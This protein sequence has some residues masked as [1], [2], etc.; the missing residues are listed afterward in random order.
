[1]CCSRS[2][3]KSPPPERQEK[4][5][6]ATETGLEGPG[7]ERATGRESATAPRPAP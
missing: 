1:M 4:I 5:P 6:V 3:D 2:G 7:L